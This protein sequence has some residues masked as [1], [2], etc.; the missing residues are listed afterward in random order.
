MVEKRENLLADIER[1]L[2]VLND[3]S[4]VLLESLETI[5]SFLTGVPSEVDEVDD[6]LRSK[7][8]EAFSEA[9]GWLGRVSDEVTSALDIV[10]R[11]NKIASD[12]VVMG[13]RDEEK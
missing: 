6:P 9:Q 3:H 2:K 11:A 13:L 1:N 12:L 10:D 7:V 5:G 4:W 8:P